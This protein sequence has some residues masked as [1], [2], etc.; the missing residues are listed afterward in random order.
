MKQIN[1]HELILQFFINIKSVY[2]AT[3]AFQFGSVQFSLVQFSPVQF[4]SVAL[5]AP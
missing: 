5:Y 1:H 2:E 4:I 3:D